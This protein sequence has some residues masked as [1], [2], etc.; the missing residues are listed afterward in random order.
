MIRIWVLLVFWLLTGLSHG[1]QE[2]PEQ[3]LVGE[4]RV[5]WLTK[6]LAE[7]GNPPPPG[8]E[9]YFRMEM[10]FSLAK[11]GRLSEAQIQFER[12]LE[13]SKELDHP[14]MVIT[15]LSSLLDIAFQ[16]GRLEEARDYC[17]EAIEIA[18]SMDRPEYVQMM[19]TNLGSVEL[20]LGNHSAAVEALTVALELH[21]EGHDP[22][23]LATLLS[24]L[25]VAYL[26]L[27]DHQNALAALDRAYPIMVEAEN[28]EGIAAVLSNQGESYILAGDAERALALL[29]DSLELRMNHSL[30]GAASISHRGIGQAL[31]SLGRTAEALVSLETAL[32]IQ[33]RL[34]LGP[35]IVASLT[36]MAEAY[37]SLRLFEKA[38]AQAVEGARLASEMSM[39]DRHILTIEAL[40]QAYVGQGDF[41]TALE[42]S[43]ALRE[44]L[45]ANS[46]A[47]LAA[48]LADFQV[49]YDAQHDHHE[50]TLLRK[51]SELQAQQ[52][53]F[54]LYGFWALLIVAL[55]GWVFFL[56][57]RRVLGKLGEAHEE[58][59]VANEGIEARNVQLVAAMDEVQLLQD[60]RR[61]ADKL[62]SIG[63]LAAGIAHDFNNVLAV[64]LGNVSLAKEV[65]ERGSEGIPLLQNAESAVEQG[66]RLST[67]LLAFAKGGEPIL[68]LHSL[69]TVVR[70]V[71][72][73]AVAG[74]T[75]SLTFDFQPDL[76]PAEIDLGQI[77]QLINNLVINAIQA[78]P[79]GGT[80][81][82]TGQNFKS[83]SG[84]AVRISVSDN[85]PGVPEE[86][87]ER[88][89]DPYFT[90]KVSGTGLGLPTAHAIASRHGGTLRIRRADVGATFELDLP[91][92]TDRV[93]AMP[94]DAPAPSVGTGRVLVL[95]DDPL[96]LTFYARALSK[97]GYEPVLTQEAGQAIQ[98]Y[99]ESCDAGS[100]IGLV[101]LDLTLPGGRGGVE[102]FKEMRIMNPGICAIVASGY[103]DAPV[104]ASHREVGFAGALA[105]PFDLNELANAL[106]QVGQTPTDEA[107]SSVGQVSGPADPHESI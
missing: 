30:E 13:L 76:L 12:S 16:V 60:D 71:A 38:E 36:V 91:A 106:K 100:P 74:S 57:K 31:L 54:M 59:R 77:S 53:E 90:T 107:Q 45:E 104:M 69:E 56:V 67:Q 55:A 25:A 34:N 42:H 101:I 80:I 65:A 32:E 58:L 47:D 15:N 64:V 2:R 1:A 62:E 35:E 26:S 85:G 75:S 22:L 61:R 46:N 5:A 99:R 10:G 89:F 96:I 28:Y 27:S 63:V 43:L 83:D 37:S 92:V 4:E 23:S 6:S 68:E 50:L 21:E 19:S 3:E 81:H 33:R 78:M 87:R 14:S 29:K 11:L 82:I 66:R 8:Q 95:D 84:P 40:V 93:P 88:V 72:R 97:L 24:N 51:D 18:E 52:R 9:L 105:K 103:S 39:R 44:K 41:E 94:P 20:R 49:Q 86:T 70:N 98:C 73:L 102:V 79:T 17:Q 48:A 7:L